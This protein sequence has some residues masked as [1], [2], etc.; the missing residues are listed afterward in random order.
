LRLFV[1][2]GFVGLMLYVGARL[3][4]WKLHADDG[5]I[6]A[7]AGLCSRFY[8]VCRGGFGSLFGTFRLAGNPLGRFGGIRKFRVP[9]VLRGAMFQAEWLDFQPGGAD[10]VQR[11]RE[12]VLSI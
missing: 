9:H 6:T 7:C 3:A 4:G 11:V 10:V 1:G 5:A 12:A 2:A 8:L